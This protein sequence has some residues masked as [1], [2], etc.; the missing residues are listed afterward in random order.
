MLTP[1][2]FNPTFYRGSPI[3]E[4]FRFVDKD[5]VAVNMAAYGPFKWQ[6]RATSS[7]KVLLELTLDESNLATGV[8]RGT[9]TVAQTLLLPVR[10]LRHDLLDAAGQKWFKGTPVIEANTTKI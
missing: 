5:D 10:V 2:T 1:V 7:S 8:L 9:A 3:S 4:E 6:I